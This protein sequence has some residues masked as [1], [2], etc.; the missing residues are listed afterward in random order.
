MSRRNRLLALSA[1]LATVTVGLVTTTGVFS[2][3]RGSDSNAYP[4]SA[5]VPNVI[6]LPEQQAVEKIVAARLRPVV[7]YTRNLPRKHG[8]VVGVMMSN[9]VQAQ[10]NLRQP[11]SL[12]GSRVTLLVAR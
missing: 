5:P 1:A 7:Q 11:I 3:D 4:A 8:F 12:E 9:L 10:V 2:N 6:G